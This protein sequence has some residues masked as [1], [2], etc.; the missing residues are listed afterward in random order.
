MV[1]P[2]ARS[3]GDKRDRTADLL[4]ASQALSQPSLLRYPQRKELYSGRLI[5]QPQPLKFP[6]LRNASKT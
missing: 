4:T 2:Q 6:H 3:G 1:L 5:R